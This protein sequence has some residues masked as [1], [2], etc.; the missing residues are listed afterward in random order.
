MRLYPK[1]TMASLKARPEKKERP[2]SW[3]ERQW[4]RLLWW[5]SER[6]GQLFES[7]PNTFKQW[8]SWWGSKFVRNMNLVAAQFLYKWLHTCF[9]QIRGCVCKFDVAFK[10]FYDLFLKK[11]QANDL[12]YRNLT[13]QTHFTFAGCKNLIFTRM[14]NGEKLVWVARSSC[15]Q[16]SKKFFSTLSVCYKSS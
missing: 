13:K 5:E 12:D 14:W 2:G 8:N 15:H 16:L 10:F 1:G 11:H 9:S 6:R 3:K 4:Q 7:L